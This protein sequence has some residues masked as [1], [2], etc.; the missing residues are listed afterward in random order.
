M[1]QPIDVVITWV[2]GQDRQLTEKRKQYVQ[3]DELLHED[4]AGTTRYTSIGEIQWCIASI[5]RFAP[6]VR[7]IFVVTDDQDPNLTPFLEAHFP[8]GYIPV[9]IVDHRQIFKGYEQFLPTFNSLSI[10]TMLWRIPGLSR[11]FLEMNDD[12]MLAAPVSPEDFFVDEDTPICFASKANMPLTRLTR[13]LKR[14]KDG[15]RRLTFKGKM[16][17]AAKIAGYHWTFLKMDH[18][19]RALLRDVFEECLGQHPEL[20]ERNIRYRFRDINQFNVEELHY[21]H[22]ARQ[23]HLRLIKSRTVLFY[24]EPK[25]RKDYIRRKLARLR[26]GNYKFCCFNNL[27]QTT[28]AELRDIKA[29]I[30]ETLNINI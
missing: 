13:L 25:K 28:E 5:N 12:F 24:L 17:E 29:W 2:D 3:S 10:E 18:T 8:E 20:M 4:I 14:R 15:T 6:W 27:N 22:L 16:I 11:H 30:G 7:R 21:L 1:N 9:E 23:K 26:A 19:P